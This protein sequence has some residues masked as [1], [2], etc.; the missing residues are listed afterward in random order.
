MTVLA[1]CLAAV[2]TLSL[3]VVVGIFASSGREDQPPG[4]GLDYVPAPRGPAPIETLRD[5]HHLHPC[6]VC[7][8]RMAVPGSLLCTTCHATD[9]PLMVPDTIPEG[10]SW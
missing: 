4:A 9:A 3:V 6:A 8:T 2:W 5:L 7:P 10:A 1:W